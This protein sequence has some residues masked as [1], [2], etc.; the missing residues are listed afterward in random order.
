[1]TVPATSLHG[2][3]TFVLPAGNGKFLDQS[4]SPFVMAVACTRTRCSS[5][6]KSGSGVGWLVIMVTFVL[7]LS[8][9]RMAFCVDLMAIVDVGVEMCV[10]VVLEVSKLWWRV[11]SDL[12]V[13][14]EVLFGLLVIAGDDLLLCK[15]TASTVSHVHSIGQ[16]AYLSAVD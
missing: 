16:I 5:E 9:C 15:T 6:S 8:G 12:S 14:F 3:R 1:M 13:D 2:T 10:V 4:N 7:I 11:L